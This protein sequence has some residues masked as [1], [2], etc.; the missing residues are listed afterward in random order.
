MDDFFGESPVGI[1]PPGERTRTGERD[2]KM[3]H[4][5]LFAFLGQPAFFFDNQY[6]MKLPERRVSNQAVQ[7]HLRAG[8]AAAFLEKKC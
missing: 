6:R 4:L 7:G 3:V 5:V 8:L 1:K 2:E